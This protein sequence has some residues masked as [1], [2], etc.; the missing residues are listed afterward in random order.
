MSIKCSVFIGTSL[1]GF[2]ARPDGSIDWLIAGENPSNTEDYGYQAFADTIDGMVMGRNTYE[3][4][5]TFPE[6]QYKGKRV[7][8][9]TT[10]SPRIPDH[11]ADSVEIAHESPVALVKRLEREGFKRLYVDGGKTI[12]SFLRAGLIDDM[13]ITQLPVLIGEGIPLFGPLAHDLRFKHIETI[14]YPNGYVQS[15]YERSS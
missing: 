11:L 14:T 4:A 12:Q 13:T 6:W 15:K 3:L 10:G 9:L 7:F 2:I 5:I 8:V 1:D